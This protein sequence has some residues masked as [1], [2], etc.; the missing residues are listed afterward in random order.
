MKVTLIVKYPDV[1]IYENVK[2]NVLD[3]D[4]AKTDLSIITV[5]VGVKGNNFY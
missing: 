2:L 1:K 3:I 5:E 4:R